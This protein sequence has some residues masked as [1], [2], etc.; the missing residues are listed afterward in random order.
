MPL[1]LRRSIGAERSLRDVGLE[2]VLVRERQRQREVLRDQID[3]EERRERARRGVGAVDARERE[4]RAQDA[5]VA[6]RG[7]QKLV[8]HRRVDPFPNR[9][10]AG[11]RDRRHRRAGD[12][13]VAELRGLAGAVPADEHH[14]RAERL[15][16]RPGALERLLGPADHDGQRRLRGAARTAAHRR[17]EDVQPR[18]LRG[19]PARER[20]W[21][22]RHVDE[23]RPGTGARPHSSC[24]EHHVLDRSRRREREQ[25]DVRRAGSLGRRVRTLRAERLDT[26]R[27]EIAADDLVPRGDEVPRH[28]EAHRAEADH[29]DPVHGSSGAR[30]RRLPAGH[31]GGRSMRRRPR[32]RARRHVE[33]R[34]PGPRTSGGGSARCGRPCA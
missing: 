24:A 12:Q 25:H 2:A 14:E 18:T 8:E 3:G 5:R 26:R 30:C 9:D 1:A 17:V 33:H 7:G 23:E 19:E 21:A 28:G 10:R 31:V 32:S 11:L 29:R 34:G 22:R 4:A 27:V 15:E 16:E 20:G 13:V 6:G